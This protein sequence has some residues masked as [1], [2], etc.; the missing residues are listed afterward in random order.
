MSRAT[1]SDSFTN[2]F[3]RA[4]QGHACVVEGLGDGLQQVP[5][6]LWSRAADRSDAALLDHCDGPTL[7]IGCGPGRMTQGLAERGHVALGIDVVHEAVRQTRDRG[8]PALVR[9]VFD[10]L[11]GEGRWRS[12]L[13]ADGNV[14]IGGDPAVLLARLRQVLDP[15]GRVVVDVA[16]PG[17]PLRSVWASLVCEG[18]RSK[19][20][21]WAVVGVDDIGALAREAG[22]GALEC[23]EHDGR[24]CAVLTEAA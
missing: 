14:G 17:V 1:G 6:H 22:F 19:P 5:V 7:D 23:H 12:A 3:A 9:D 18:V 16:P 20:F 4:L 2:V 24:W 10:A 11:P 21:R 8:V 15:R 13:L